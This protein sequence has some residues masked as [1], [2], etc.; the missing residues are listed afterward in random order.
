MTAHNKPSSPY[1]LRRLG[2]VMEPDLSRPEE[3]WGVL[4]PASVRASGGDLYLFP[5]EVA[6]GN[7]SRIGRCRVCFDAGGNPVGVERLGFALEP[8]TTFERA[9]RTHGGVEDPRITFL[10]RLGQFVMA[11]TA[12]GALGPRIA[13][14]ASHDGLAWKR[15]GLVRFDTGHG[16]DFNRYGNKDSVIFPDLVT[17]PDGRECYGLLHRPTYLVENNNGTVELILP[18]DVS[19][20]RAGI[21][22]SYLEADGAGSD[23]EKLT[24]A[25]QT[26][27]LA[28]P[29]QPWEELKIGAGTPPVLLEEGWLIYYHGVSGEERPQSGEK[30]VWYRAGAMI[31]DRH[32]PRRILYRSQNPVLQPESSTETDGVVPNVVFPT[33]VDVQGRRL[34]VYFGAADTRIGAATT[35]LAKEPILAASAPAVAYHE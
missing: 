30:R 8:E 29:E 10:P 4:N 11:Y 34:D 24:M 27:L 12:L 35:E 3:A 28:N 22:I 20:A 33:A 2:V 7:Y 26:Q 6:E 1:E 25:S 23:L 9:E 16:V 13:L 15:L 17:A 31:L 5:R 18:R 19:D 32:D 21:W 14:A